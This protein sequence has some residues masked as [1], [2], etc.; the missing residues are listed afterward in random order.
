M[1]GY[2]YILTNN[3]L[4]VIYTGSTGELKK[5]IYLHKKRLIEGFTKKYNVGRL[6]YFEMFSTIEEAM[7]RER[8]IKG[9]NRA[10]KNAL[11]ERA[12]FN[13]RDLYEDLSEDEAGPC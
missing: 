2:V 10:K 11:V 13:W 12:N 5:R 3:R 7:L 6:V 4:N 8:Q 1:R 9:Y